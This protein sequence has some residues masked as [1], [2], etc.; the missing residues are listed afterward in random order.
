MGHPRSQWKHKKYK[1]RT[2]FGRYAQAFGERV[3]ILTCFL[4]NGQFHNITF[5]SHEAA[6]SLGWKKRK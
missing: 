5:E 1:S 4:R 3:F 6:K 2:Y